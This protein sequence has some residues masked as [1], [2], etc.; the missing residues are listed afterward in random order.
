MKEKS[1]EVSMPPYKDEALLVAHLLGG[2]YG[3]RLRIGQTMEERVSEAIKV[4]REIRRQLSE[5]EKFSL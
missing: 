3:F 1:H 5:L 2:R 4:S